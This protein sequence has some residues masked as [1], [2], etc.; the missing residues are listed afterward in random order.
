MG[1]T[2]TTKEAIG[3]LGRLQNPEPY[4]QQITPDTF[5][6][7]GMAI[8]ALE[9]KRNTKLNKDRVLLWDDVEKDLYTDGDKIFGISI[10]LS[11]NHA[12]FYIK[13]KDGS[14]M[15]IMT[16][17]IYDAIDVFNGDKGLDLTTYRPV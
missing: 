4:E 9:A 1:R 5:H 6:A 8:E 12:N 2:V 11:N 7:L 15:P 3:I 16:D 17:N 10:D 14:E 13:Y